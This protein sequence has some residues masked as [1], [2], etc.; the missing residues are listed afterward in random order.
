MLHCILL[1]A[2][3]VSVFVDIVKVTNK[4]NLP[5]FNKCFSQYSDTGADC[6]QEIV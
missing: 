1:I 3:A 4:Q 6:V 2:V 5:R